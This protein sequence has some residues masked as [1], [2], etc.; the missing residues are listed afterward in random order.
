MLT[1]GFT[2]LMLVLSV[3]V[4][5]NFNPVW[6]FYSVTTSTGVTKE[7]STN[8]ST[9]L[10]HT[11]PSLFVIGPIMLEE[12]KCSPFEQTVFINSINFACLEQ[13]NKR[14]T[15]NYL[16]SARTLRMVAWHTLNWVK[17]V[18]PQGWKLFCWW[19]QIWFL[20]DLRII[21]ATG[22]NIN[23]AARCRGVLSTLSWKLLQ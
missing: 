13:R 2:S 5:N 15:K 6:Y 7:F 3:N 18:L 1:S 11:I 16:N 22:L 19:V 21:S 20:I 9:S 10:N 4:L 12:R 14:G 23:F 8:H 17:F